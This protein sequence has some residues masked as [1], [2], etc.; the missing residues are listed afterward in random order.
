MRLKAQIYCIYIR[1]DIM[2]YET[3][4]VTADV[5]YLDLYYLYF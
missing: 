2:S 4:P 3:T 5:S 1:K